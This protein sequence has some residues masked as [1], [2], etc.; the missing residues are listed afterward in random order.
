[1]AVSRYR[2]TAMSEYTTTNLRLDR[3]TYEELRYQARR[4]GTSVATLVREAVARYLGHVPDD[5][6]PVG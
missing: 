2:G 1:M 3:G 5:G 6:I 4:R